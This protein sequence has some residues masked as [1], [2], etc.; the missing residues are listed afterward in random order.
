MFKYLYSLVYKE[1]KI[2][3]NNIIDT[4]EKDI[5]K[6]SLPIL[7][8]DGTHIIVTNSYSVVKHKEIEQNKKESEIQRLQQKYHVGG[9]NAYGEH[10][11]SVHLNQTFTGV[12]FAKN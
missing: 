9:F 6:Q 2:E 10:I 1:K 12:Y 7:Q 8:P 11:H 3:N 5:E 4:L